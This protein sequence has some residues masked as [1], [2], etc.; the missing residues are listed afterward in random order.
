LIIKEAYPDGGHG[1]LTLINLPIQTQ[2]MSLNIDSGHWL[3]T[4]DEIVINQIAYHQFVADKKM[5]DDIFINAQNENRTFKLVGIIEEPLTGASVYTQLEPGKINSLRIQ[6]HNAEP[7]E[8]EKIATQL[9]LDFAHAG[10]PINSLVTELFRQ[11]SGNGHLMIMVLILVMIAVAMCVVGLFSLATVMSTN[12][13]ERLRE[14][15]VMRS[16]GAENATIFSLV[17]NEAFLIALLSYLLSLPIAAVF[18]TLMARTLGNISLQ[19]LSLAF[20]TKG[21]VIWFFLIL[22]GAFIASL[23]PALHAMRFKL[24]EVLAFL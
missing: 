10:V 24:R 11:Q 12:V 6:L 9:K 5:G 18:S 15:A 23:A 13:S 3:Q 2:T 1:S 7:A 14:F 16:L 8:I 19:P 17:I 22:V 4:A 21:L 20:S